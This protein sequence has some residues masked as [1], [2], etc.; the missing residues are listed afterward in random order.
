MN[1]VPIDKQ[2]AFDIVLPKWPQMKVIGTPITVDQAKEII[3]RTDNF[4]NYVGRYGGGNDRKFKARFDKNTGY[5]KLNQFTEL[6]FT[7]DAPN[8]RTARY[9]ANMA[10]D[11]L[12]HMLQNIKCEYV[13]SDF[14]STCYAG[15]PHGWC[16]SDGTIKFMDNVGKWPSVSEIHDEW[17]KIAST[18]E[19]LDIYVT[20][21]NK[22]SCEENAQPL[23]TF[24]IKDG[25]VS[26]YQGS[27]EPFEN[28]EDTYAFSEEKFIKQINGMNTGNYSYERGLPDSWYDEFAEQAR[29]FVD[30]VYSQ[31]ELEKYEYLLKG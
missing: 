10:E 28:V 1:L 22:E 15:G 25:T 27:D 26:V 18:W 9:A 12:Y 8:V 29:K 31:Y 2:T 3:F 21:M 11:R 20:L 5:N 6:P 17:Q 4:L 23:V 13:V 30:Q 14:G 7:D 19:F 16:H 24:H